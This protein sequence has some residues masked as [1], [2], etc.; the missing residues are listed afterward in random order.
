MQPKH[1]PKR[2]TMPTTKSNL[3]NYTKLLTNALQKF[4]YA[5]DSQNTTMVV[6]KRFGVPPR[7]ELVSRE[8]AL[9]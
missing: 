4:V 2:V 9:E 5:N 7:I 6:R 8:D 1:V 3:D